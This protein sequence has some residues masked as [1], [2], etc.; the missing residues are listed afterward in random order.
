MRRF[1][2]VLFVVVCVSVCVVMP[3]AWA[4][5]RSAEFRIDNSMTW[6]GIARVHLE[7]ENL[8]WVGESLNGRFR[9]RIPLAPKRNDSGILVLASDKSLDEVRLTGGTLV[10]SAQSQSTGKIHSVVCDVQPDGTIH[11][12]VTTE[13]RTLDFDS[14]YHTVG[15][16]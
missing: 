8:R 7:V 16:S 9:L 6:V 4:E 13:K 12:R 5:S 2:L 1:L 14:R 15:G 11:I 3:E 10:G